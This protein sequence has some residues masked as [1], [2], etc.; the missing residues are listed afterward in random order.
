MN[1]CPSSSESGQP[2]DTPLCRVSCESASVA[3]LLHRTGNGR[4]LLLVSERTGL[5]TLLDATVLDA[6][7]SLTPEAATALVRAAVQER[8]TT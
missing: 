5:S 2:A 3:V 1:N 7:C 8:T 6:L 4:R